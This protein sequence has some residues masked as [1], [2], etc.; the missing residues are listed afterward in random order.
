MSST[1]NAPAKPLQLDPSKIYLHITHSPP[2]IPPSTVS[3]SSCNLNYI[4]Q[5]GELEG[6]GIFEVVKRD[7][8]GAVRRGED[9]WRNGEKGLLEEVKQLEGV[10]GVKVVPE[11]KQRAK[12]DEF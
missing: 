1:S 7:G 2:Q 4:G 12:R 10:K 3:H 8:G 9:L 11:M 5:V 6:E